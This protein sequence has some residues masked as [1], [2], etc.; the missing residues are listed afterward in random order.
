MMHF[1]RTLLFSIHLLLVVSGALAQYGH[2]WIKPYQPYY[3]FCV[4]QDA[5]ARIPFIA[6]QSSGINTATLNPTRVQ[7]FKNGKEQHLFIK[8][9][10]DGVFDPSDFIEL[11]TEQNRGELDAELY[12]PGSQPHS[13]YSLF[14]DTSCYFLTI[15]PDTTVVQPLRYSLSN[16]Y[17]FGTYVP[18]DY[19]WDEVIVAPAVE[20][21]DGPN[22]ASSEL[23]YLTSDYEKGE[24][25]SGAR[26]GLGQTQ[27]YTLATPFKY[28]GAGNAT[29]TVRV[30]GASDALRNTN[31][32]NHHVNVSASPDNISFATLV[33][34]IYAGYEQPLFNIPVDL[35]AIGTN[36]YIKIQSVNDIGVVSDFNSLSFVTL[37]YP[38]LFNW[39]NSTFKRFKVINT[40]GQSKTRFALTNFGNGSQTAPTILDLTSKIRVNAAYS[41]GAASVLLPNTNQPHDVVV[42]DSTDV[43]VISR[44]TPAPFLSLTPQGAEFVIITHSRLDSSAQQ[45]AQYRSGKYSVL[46]ALTDDLY[47]TYCYGVKH[48]LALKRF[49]SYLVKQAPQKPKYFLLLGKGYQND[50]I[51]KPIIGVP[52]PTDYYNRNYV[53]VLGM[54]GADALYTA[55]ITNSGGYPEV[56]IGRIPALTNEEVQQYLEKL[57]THETSPDSLQEW[58]KTTIHVSGGNNDQEQQRFA[59]QINKNKTLIEGQFIGGRV[60]SFNKNSSDATQINLKQKIVDAQNQGATLLSFLGHASLT[61]LDV[62]IGSI[63]DLSNSGKYPFYYFNGCNVGNVGEVDVNGSGN[64]YGKDYLCADR[65]GGI[66]WLAHSNFTFDGTLFNM[67]D[68]FYNRYCNSLYGAPI[69]DI[70]KSVGMASN[71]ADLL[72]KSHIIQW[73]L[74]C[75]P[76]LVLLGNALPDYKV[77]SNDVFATPTNITVQEDSFAVTVIVTN[78][79]KAVSDSLKIGVKHQLPSGTATTWPARSYAPVYFK[80]TFQYWISY[81][82]MKVLLGTNQFEITVDGNNAV[83]EGNE[84]NNKTTLS[85]FIAGSGVTALLPYNYQIVTTDSV[86]LIGQ[87]NDVLNTGAS[88]LFEL[89]TSYLFNSPAI[90]SSGVISGSAIPSWKVKL[91]HTDSQDYYWRVRLNVPENEGGVWDQHSFTAIQNGARGFGQVGFPQVTSFTKTNQLQVDTI[92]RQLEFTSRYNMVKAFIA[93]WG[94]AGLG[95][96]DPYFNTPKAG[97]C[98]GQ[99]GLVCV[100]F[101]KAS[102]KVTSQPNYPTNCNP[103]NLGTIFNYYAFNTSTLAGQSDFMQFVDSV[104]KGAYIAAYS[105]YYS[106][107]DVWS[108][109]MR[110]KLTS[111]GL[112]KVP[113]AHSYYNAFSFIAKK[114]YSNESVEDTV[115]DDT[116]I[117][118]YDTVYKSP[119]ATSEKQLKGTNTSGFFETQVIGPALSWNTCYLKFRSPEPLDESVVKVFGVRVDLTDT[120]LATAV[121]KT[122]IDLSSI[123]SVVYPYLKLHIDLIDSLNATPSQL[124]KILIT[125]T[126]ATELA[127]NAAMKYD[128]YNNQLEQGDSLRLAVAISNVS[129]TDADS[130]NVKLTITDP[131]RV[132]VFTQTQKI[133]PVVSGASYVFN[134]KITTAAFSGTNTLSLTVNDIKSVREGSYVNNFLSRQFEVTKD[135]T[136]P[137]LDVTFDGYRI[138]NGDFVSPTPVIHLK[139]KD[140]SKFKLQADTSTFVL[141]V[142]K[143]NSPVYE[144]IP[145]NSPEISFA[146]G[147]AQNNTATLEYKPAKLSDGNY[148]LKVQAKDASGNLSGNSF[149]EVD[150]QVISESTITNFYPYPNPGTTN[151]RFVFTLTG[152]RPP[153]QLL[154]RIM[155]ITGKVVKEITQDEFGPIK[156]GNNIS[157]YGWDGTDNFG[158]RL[159]N[160][161]YL[162]QVMTRIDGQSIKKR[163]TDADRF[164]VHNTGK[165]YLLK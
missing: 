123:N 64:I 83:N 56:P 154:I 36:T 47:D 94:H 6:L 115:Y 87:N 145:L 114:G 15:L 108:Q 90:Q 95:V 77:A 117:F 98:I 19:F 144:R 147:N 50:K 162:Y 43:N 54:P 38:R 106:G 159:A 39:G 153:E 91:Y 4:G 66:G 158:D 131:N 89:D 71:T 138:M 22:M 124:D 128:F 110:D 2:E 150:F 52:N 148:S 143:P 142:K 35:S 40:Q 107:A 28:T 61:V 3:K 146:A 72:T 161:V 85:I 119:L 156:I 118:Q 68:A 112:V 79:G 129:D 14:S 18:E 63:G 45:Y 48:P 57:I 93:R 97:D 163:T 17:N 155:T 126:P 42:F 46:K 136:N 69:G 11:Y 100:L 75:D 121:N 92:T 59:G 149:Y 74:Q 30:I 29:A 26:V 140:N 13:F 78:L 23:K 65:K 53:P 51:R 70:M 44:L 33:D 20:Y 8:G 105:Y 80:D 76:A 16:D 32:K 37:R 164:I 132:N 81:P 137:F 24:G 7:V 5:V 96:L 27:T 99:G 151:I 104:S 127:I 12:A 160:G 122:T 120:L 130:V 102:I 133:P 34:E 84:F 49:A 67:M 21:L 116:F 139:S 10:S 141:F 73:Q 103:N 157:A 113:A 41:A 86:T 152:S 88:Y 62:D 134:S 135:N 1:K 101:D 111:L 82:D 55:G 165:I 25:W 60:V 125:Y 109:A 9:E 58:R 31:G